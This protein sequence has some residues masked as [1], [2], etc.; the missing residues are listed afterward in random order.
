[1]LT[2]YN[3]I[4]SDH[5]LR[6]VALAAL[7]CGLASFTAIHLLHHVCCSE[8]ARHS[9]W[10]SIAAISTG[11]GIWSTH[12]IGM[13]AFSPALPAGY[14]V[15]LTVISLLAAVML[16][17]IGFCVALIPGLAGAMWIGGAIVGGGIAVMHYTGMAAFD[18]AGTVSWNWLLVM[19]SIALGALFGT[20]ALP[21]GL[22]GGSRRWK[23]AGTLLLTLAI[24]SHHFTAMA[25][26]SITPDNSIGLSPLAI[27]SQWLAVG[28]AVISLAVILLACAALSLDLRERRR[29]ALEME[30]MRDLTNAAVEGL[31]VCDGE[32]IVTVNQSFAH[33][34]NRR[35]DQICGR[36]LGA[37]VPDTEKRRMLFEALGQAVEAD[38]SDRQGALIPVELIAHQISYN[39]RLHNVVAFRDLRD[40]RNA[41]AQI[42]YLAHHDPLTGLG[43]RASFDQR[44]DHEIRLH[45]RAG[46]QLAVLCLDLDGFKDVNDLYGHAAGDQLLQEIAVRFSSVLPDDCMLA[47]LGGDEFAVVAPQVTDP[48]H[49]SSLAERLLKCLSGTDQ[50]RMPTGGLISVSIGIALYP[51][52]ARDRTELLSS[53]DTALYRAKLEGKGTYRFFEAA[54]GVQIRER[55]SIEHDLRNAIQ[56]G[57]LSLVYQPQAQ[58]DTGR[59]LG[60]EVLLRWNHPVRGSVPPSDFIPIAEES[61][62]ILKIGE[63]VMRH[64]C[65][66]AAGWKRPLNIAV[67]VSPL[68][69]GSEGF[70]QLIQSILHET[71]LSP[72]RLEIEITETALIRDPN[73]AMLTLQ[74]LKALGINIAM[75]DFGT[76]YSSLSNLQA[77][78]FDKIKIDRSFIQA[79]HTKPQ[80]AAIV[81]AVLGL[82]RGLGLPVI[83]E[84]VET[85]EELSFLGLEGCTEAQGYL[86]GRPVP[87]AELASIISGAAMASSRTLMRVSAR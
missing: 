69:L 86:F 67:N 48:A 58:V 8:G 57:E 53:A 61:G 16:T 56:N 41:E 52:D 28:V 62:L 66:E 3:C 73:R 49:V 35:P 13:L 15:A 77:F 38:L 24:C 21:T 6:L 42:R 26:V 76:G 18:V 68:Q 60:F 11:F 65:Q 10:L 63:W 25:A 85:S 2:V 19:I 20:V 37:Y 30:R 40:R 23:L 36:A 29:V 71:Q 70:V 17:G 54:M 74:K 59:V 7:V 51:S 83:A 82:G 5:D 45:Q 72:E 87:I 84:G 79:V 55:R 32:N 80:A 12:F 14:D 31:V 39:G 27:P 9:I 33:L 81:R 46:Q 22:K 4:V 50:A 64:A 43:N 75:D 78:P 47:R 1:M 44:L 34:V